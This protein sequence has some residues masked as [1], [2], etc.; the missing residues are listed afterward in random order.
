MPAVASVVICVLVALVVLDLALVVLDV[1]L[2][3]RC[4]LDVVCC[5]YGGC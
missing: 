3:T 2:R 5:A 1:A 4:T